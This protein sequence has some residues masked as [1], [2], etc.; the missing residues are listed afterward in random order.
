MNTMSSANCQL[1]VDS[2]PLVHIVDKDAMDTTTSHNLGQ[3]LTKGDTTSTPG[4]LI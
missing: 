1:P 2:Q 4:N 3:S